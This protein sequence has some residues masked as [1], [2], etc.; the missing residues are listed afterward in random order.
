MKKRN[1][2]S[3]R[4]RTLRM[5]NIPLRRLEE[6]SINPRRIEDP[7]RTPEGGNQSPITVSLN[8]ARNTVSLITWRSRALCYLF[9]IVFDDFR[10]IKN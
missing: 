3:K 8:R 2:T 7:R 6:K 1:K 10:K 5:M 9:L 4:A